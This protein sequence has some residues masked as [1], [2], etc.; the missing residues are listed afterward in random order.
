[1]RGIGTCWLLV[2]IWKE[3]MKKLTLLFALAFAL[4]AEV[5]CLNGQG[6]LQDG[7]EYCA[8]TLNFDSL[9]SIDFTAGIEPLLHLDLDS[10]TNVTF[11]DGHYADT[12]HCVFID[13]HE[14]GTVEV[15]IPD[16]MTFREALIL[17]A[18]AVRR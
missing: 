7:Q 11:C 13:W 6:P 14:D 10:Y 16:G 1:M 8:T 17:A 15:Q 18:K 3:I 12:N 4:H 2:G 9:A 5:L